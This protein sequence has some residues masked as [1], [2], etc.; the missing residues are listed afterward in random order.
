[1]ALGANRGWLL[2]SLA[3]LN[4]SALFVYCSLNIYQIRS[5]RTV[6]PNVA[7]SSAYCPS[8]PA[9]PIPG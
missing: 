5:P 2:I 1:M 9:L 7:H 8:L 6:V 3:A 4:I